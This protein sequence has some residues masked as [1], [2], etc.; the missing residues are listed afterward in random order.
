MQHGRRDNLSCRNR[1]THALCPL[2]SEIM[3]CA[4]RPCMQWQKFW[5]V[6]Q[7]LNQKEPIVSN[8]SACAAP[9]LARPPDVCNQQVQSMLDQPV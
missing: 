6:K 1:Q 4:S 9:Q 8:P 5:F 2:S 7:Q 3:F